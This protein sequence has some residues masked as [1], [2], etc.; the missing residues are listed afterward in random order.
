MKVECHSLGDGQT[1]LIH[2]ETR[3]IITT[4][5]PIDN[6]GKGR[7]FSPTDLFVSALSSCILTIMGKVASNNNYKMEG[8]E[9]S[10]EKVMADK[11]RR[12]GKIILDIK[13]KDDLEPTLKNKLLRS[14][15][16]CP[17]HRSIHPEIQ[18]VVTHN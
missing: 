17:V 14:V 11:P 4:D 7:H 18:L 2:E 12:I 10:A 6:D 15:E 5:L 9:I 3:E 13:F 8:T 16:A 1:S